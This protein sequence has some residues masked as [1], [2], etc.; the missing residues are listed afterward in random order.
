V[1]KSEIHLKQDKWDSLT[2]Q[3]LKEMFKGDK[4]EMP[5]LEDRLKILK[6]TG[7]ILKEKFNGSVIQ[8]VKRAENSSLKLIEILKTEFGEIWDDSGVFKGRRVEFMK[9]AQIFCGDLWAALDGKG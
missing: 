9:R 5:M 3:E 1:N 2:I 6:E 8:L 7:K 4:G